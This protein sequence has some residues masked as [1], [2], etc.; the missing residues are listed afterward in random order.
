MNSEV[1]AKVTIVV[2]PRERFSVAVKSLQSIVE[3]TTAPYELLY[4]DGNSPRPVRRA[5]E[6]VAGEHGFRVIRTD[7]YLPPNHARNLAIPHISTPYVVFIDNDVVVTPGWLER[8][9]DCAECTDAAI[10]SPLIC[11]GEPLHQ[12]VHCAGGE[13]GILEADQRGRRIHERIF[14]QGRKVA[15]QDYKRCETGLAEFHCM[16][17]KTS[18]LQDV[19]ELDDQLLNTREHLDLCMEAVARGGTIWFEPESVVTYLNEAP[20]KASDVVYY[21]LRWGDDWERRSLIR[22]AEKWDLSTRGALGRRLRNVGLRRHYKLV[23]PV[24]AAM[25]LGVARQRTQP[26][27]IR[28]LGA[29]DKRLNALLNQRHRRQLQ[30]GA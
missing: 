15:D 17:V 28:H 30:G 24:A 9:I 2:A 6:H 7:H 27:F 23:H 18:L 16:L 3:H 26:V 22:F 14:H 19:G 4:V 10:V 29:L 20:M 1:P 5:I 11:Q 8:L 13:C 25:T 21:M 12:I